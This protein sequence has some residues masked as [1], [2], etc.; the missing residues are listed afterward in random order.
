MYWTF[1][2]EVISLLSLTLPTPWADKFRR[3]VEAILF[4]LPETPSTVALY[5]VSHCSGRQICFANSSAVFDRRRRELRSTEYAVPQL[6]RYFEDVRAGW[7][8]LSGEIPDQLNCTQ[9]H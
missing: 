6:V 9:C 4:A 2:N 7:T 3:S 8:G 1:Q 5:P